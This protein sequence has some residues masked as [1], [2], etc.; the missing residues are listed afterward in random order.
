MLVFLCLQWPLMDLPYEETG[1]QWDRV[2]RIK[3]SK[4]TTQRL[5]C[6]LYLFV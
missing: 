4:K 1:L 2:P 6:L 5:V 3:R